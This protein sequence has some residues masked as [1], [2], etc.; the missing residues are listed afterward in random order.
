MATNRT[1]SRLRVL[2]VVG[3]I[4]S[5]RES[6]LPERNL[7]N[8]GFPSSRTYWCLLRDQTGGGVTPRRSSNLKGEWCL[9]ARRENSARG[10]EYWYQMGIVF[11]TFQ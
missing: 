6:R 5:R 3:F 7:G 11:S 1:V 2:N 8:A 9:P 4:A 10:G